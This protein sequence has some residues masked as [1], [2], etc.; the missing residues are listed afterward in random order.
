MCP[1]FGSVGA[2][3]NK[4]NKSLL[5]VISISTGA[6]AITR[7][8]AGLCP[9]NAA[10]HSQNSPPMKRKFHDKNQMRKRL[11]Y[12]NA[13]TL[14]RSRTTVKKKC[15]VN[16]ENSLVEWP[17]LINPTSCLIT[18]LHRDDDSHTSRCQVLSY[19]KAYHS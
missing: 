4:H 2:E 14:F 15:T 18:L 17:R 19:C 7:T 5:P 8:P 9:C 12:Y 6:T 10:A 1:Q 3:R 16:S 11:I 13:L